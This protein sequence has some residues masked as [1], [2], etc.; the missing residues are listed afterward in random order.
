LQKQRH[1]PNFGV[2]LCSNP[3]KLL[4]SQKLARLNYRYEEMP[5]GL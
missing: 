3:V 5:G 1:N 4:C 2:D